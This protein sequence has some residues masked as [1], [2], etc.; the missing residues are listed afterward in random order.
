MAAK[1]HGLKRCGKVVIVETLQYR[2]EKAKQPPI[3]NY[4]Y[5]RRKGSYP[6]NP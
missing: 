2:L 1:S 3:G 4:S 6:E 5:G